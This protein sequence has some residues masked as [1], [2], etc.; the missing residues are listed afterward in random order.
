MTSEELKHENA[1]LKEQLTQLVKRNIGLINENEE[2]KRH[3]ER[4]R[5]L[6]IYDPEF[7]LL[8]EF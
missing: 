2:L 4:Q 5:P 8:T 3:I 6:T 1:R 7:K